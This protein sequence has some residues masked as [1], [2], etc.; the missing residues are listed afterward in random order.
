MPCPDSERARRNLKKSTRHSALPYWPLKLLRHFIRAEYLEEI[1]GDMEER[2]QDDLEN[3]GIRKARRLYV[4]DSLKLLRPALI[5]K[6]SGDYRLNQYGMTRYNFLFALKRLRRHKLYSVTSIAGLSIGLACF[7]AVFIW[8]KYLSEYDSFHNNA[9][10]I[11]CVKTEGISGNNEF[12]ALS[13]PLL[14]GNMLR[15]K[16]PSIEAA[17]FTANFFEEK[18]IK[19][20]CNQKDFYEDGNIIVSDSNFFDVFSF[21]VVFGDSNT[22]LRG[23]NKVVLSK[24][25]YEKL[26]N[27]DDPVGK[28]ITI[29]SGEYEV[30]AVVKIPP[31][32]QMQFGYIIS[33]SSFRPDHHRYQWHDLS[34]PLYLKLRENAP[35]DLI[36]TSLYDAYIKRSGIP[37]MVKMA[38]DAELSFSL[39]PYREIKYE[40]D[41][42][43]PPLAIQSNGLTKHIYL[44]L[45]VSAG[46][47]IL[48]IAALN[49]IN[50]CIVQAEK[51]KKNTFIF[52]LFGSRRHHIIRLFIEITTIYSISMVIAVGMTWVGLK[53]MSFSNT[54]FISSIL[55]PENLGM[56]LLVSLFLSMLTA[57]SIGIATRH[58][59]KVIGHILQVHSRNPIT[60]H[61]GLVVFQFTISTILV[62]SAIFIFR[63]FE[64]MLRQELG[65]DRDQIIIVKDA[66]LLGDK[67]G[68]FKVNILKYNSIEAASL[69]DY[70]P[71]QN[72]AFNNPLNVPGIPGNHLFGYIVADSNFIDVY[73]IEIT[74]EIKKSY[75]NN[76]C[77]INRAGQKELGHIG[78]EPLTLSAN[79]LDYDLKAVINPLFEPLHFEPRPMI[80]VPFPHQNWG[81]E[82]LSVKVSGEAS[83][84]AL[85]ALKTEW[86]QLT[87]YPFEYEFL[88]QRF[89]NL[90][91][92]EKIISRVLA[93]FSWVAGIISLIGLLAITLNLIGMR[94]KEIAI[95][96]VVG[97]Q[98]GQVI[99]LLSS[100][101]SRWLLLSIGMALPLAYMALTWWLENF[102]VRTTLDG[103]TFLLTSLMIFVVSLL[104]VAFHTVK[105]ASANPVDFLRDG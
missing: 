18:K 85:K 22:S 61:A 10:R 79:G 24:G 5:K 65:F 95:R 56:L 98:V 71:S 8:W 76:W 91:E 57:L 80:I 36:M 97:A 52:T 58:L 66:N 42:M 64:T 81:R 7:F 37:D 55:D 46:L 86:D 92:N 4:W 30:T 47:V 23:P 21:P 100:T 88:D 83:A 44:Y 27:N 12:Q 9:D 49:F 78:A 11:F 15:A 93:M 45:L 75:G 25:I 84:N 53:Q 48:V 38:K 17:T 103:P 43:W 67:A 20:S 63:Q 26:F 35:K 28:I 39:I 2:F 101:F 54:H 72:V 32:S 60:L 59:G 69:S 19:V 102:T 16:F 70:V 73:S 105:A 77:V 50:L 82:K 62:L 1:E 74:E 89:A 41:F 3:Y 33:G 94:T 31:N 90:Y 104:T 51:D 13:A 6:A 68:I 14:A 87:D 29:N 40:H 96:K 34:F 99:L